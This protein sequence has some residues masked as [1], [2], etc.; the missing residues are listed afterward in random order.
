M[1]EI[2]DATNLGIR[3]QSAPFETSPD[4]PVPP[5]RRRTRSASAILIRLSVQTRGRFPRGQHRQPDQAQ[6]AEREAA[7]PQQV[8]P[9]E[10]VNPGEAESAAP[11]G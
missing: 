3:F 8:R 10:L 2:R 1:G 4:D 5:E 11:R 6:Q 9:S 7:H